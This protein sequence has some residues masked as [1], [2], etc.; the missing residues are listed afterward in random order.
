MI[1]DRAIVPPRWTRDGHMWAVMDDERTMVE[2]DDAR[3][4]RVVPPVRPPA[5]PEEHFRVARRGLL[6]DALKVRARR[7]WPRCGV[8]LPQHIERRERRLITDARR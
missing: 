8:H 3:V 7:E 1:L 5:G 4:E 2:E 6:L